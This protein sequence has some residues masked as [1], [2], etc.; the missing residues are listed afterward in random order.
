[1]GRMEEGQ[2]KINGVMFNVN[3]VVGSLEEVK[4]VKC[5]CNVVENVLQVYVIIFK[6]DGGNDEGWVEVRPPYRQH[7][8]G[9]KYYP[10]A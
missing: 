2:V 8:T 1:M 7:C 6:E 9:S 3:E 10:N 4:G 5:F